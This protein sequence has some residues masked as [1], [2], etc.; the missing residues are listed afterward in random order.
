MMIESQSETQCGPEAAA[1]RAFQSAVG[2]FVAHR[3]FLSDLQKALALDPNLVAAHALNGI[4]QAMMG[5]ESG[6]AASAEL[7]PATFA[8][9]RQSGGGSVRD[10]ALAEAH[11]CAAN[12]DLATAA[13]RLERQLDADPLDLLALKLS[14]ALRF[15]L[16][17]GRQMLRTT[18]TAIAHWSP[19]VTGYGFVLGCH[20][21]GLE[22]SGARQQAEVIGRRAVSHEPGD[23]WG[24]HA[25]AHVLEMDGRTGEGRIWLEPQR[26]HW[27]DCGAFGKHLVWHL[28]LF[29]L[30]EGRHESAL[31]LY[32]GGITPGREGCFREMSNAVSL[33]WRL[34]LAGVPVADRWN[35]LAEMAFERRRD[36]TY[37]F[38]SLHN[39]LALI[40]AKKIDAARDVVAAL[41][42]KHGA[43]GAAESVG[44]R[45]ARV[46]VDS[47]GFHDQGKELLSL[48]RALPELGGSTAQR[49]VFLLS[50]LARAADGGDAGLVAG[51]TDI[52]QQQRRD[53]RFQAVIR[54]RLIA[55]RKIPPSRERLHA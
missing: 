5:R 4:A 16:G 35:A 3:P 24:L 53:D 21:F 27:A 2:K 44:L 30:A 50:L 43:N 18:T 13:A 15:M 52:R 28:A 6:M 14:H 12:G 23:V 41:A 36:S 54:E 19:E 34:E 42:R 48:A 8:A 31:D 45:L 22:E 29:H 47:T 17:D 39:L 51:L 40:A 55:G 37:A 7:V 33:L 20:A 11:R 10:R 49:D 32:D 26:K 1:R 25:V 9:L 38:G 46:L